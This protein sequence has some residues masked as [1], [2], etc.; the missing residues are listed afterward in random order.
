MLKAAVALAL[1]LANAPLQCGHEADPA[2]RR[3]DTPGDA[4]WGLASAFRAKGDE[5]SARETL[6]YLLDRYPSNR[7]AVAAKEQLALPPGALT[8]PPRFGADGGSSP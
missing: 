5:K 8:P 2:Y 7:F 6:Q 4:L 3:E 1:V